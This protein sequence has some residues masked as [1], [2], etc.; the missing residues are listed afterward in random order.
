MPPLPMTV[1]RIYLPQLEYTVVDKSTE[2]TR[3]AS[4]AIFMDIYSDSQY[5]KRLSRKSA[6]TALCMYDRCAQPAGGLWG[7]LVGRAWDMLP[8]V[9]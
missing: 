5:N 4:L 7:L 2:D 9:A 6:I 3:A 1:K 8:R